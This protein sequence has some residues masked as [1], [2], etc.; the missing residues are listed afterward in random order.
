[1]VCGR[2]GE[3]SPSACRGHRAERAAVRAAGG[4]ARAGRARLVGGRTRGRGVGR[5]SP[6]RW[7]RSPGCGRGGVHLRGARECVR[8]RVW[9]VRAR[10]C[11]HPRVRSA[12]G[13]VALRRATARRARGE[14]TGRGHPVRGVRDASDRRVGIR[15][16]LARGSARQ[17]ARGAARRGPAATGARGGRGRSFVATGGG[18]RVAGRRF[19]GERAVVCGGMV[20]THPACGGS[21]RGL[22]GAAGPLGRVGDRAVGGLAGT[23]CEG[24][25]LGGRGGSRGSAVPRVGS[26]RPGSGPHRGDGRRAG[27]RDPRRRPGP[28]HACRHGSECHRVA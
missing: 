3:T 2:G 11:R 22:A 15:G 4:R 10:R 18:S 24:G 1:M 12:G 26:S 27:R 6:R 9:A 5:G 28:R 8:L 20:R 17:P 25:P 13:G 21:G 16:G 19:S 7:D 14:R 23:A